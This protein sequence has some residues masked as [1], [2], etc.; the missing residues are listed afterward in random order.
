[1]LSGKRGC[2]V[3]QF[4]NASPCKWITLREPA[5]SWKSSPF[6]V[7]TVT[8]AYSSILEIQVCASL[9]SNSNI[10]RLIGLKKS[11]TICR[12]SLQLDLRPQYQAFLLATA[13]ASISFQMPPSPLN[14][15][16]PLAA[17]QPAPVKNTQF[18]QFRFKMGVF[19]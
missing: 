7:I 18:L 1:M 13:S 19:L 6:C 8:F 4:F 17:E 14:V 12:L 9:G 10:R 2:A 5:L 3:L 11:N 16:S 15:G